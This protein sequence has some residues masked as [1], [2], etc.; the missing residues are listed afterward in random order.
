AP[1]DPTELEFTLTV[2][3]RTDSATDVITITIAKPITRNIKEMSDTLISAQIT[4]SNEITMTYNEELSTFINSYLNFTISNE[5]MPRSITG[6]D[7]SPSRETVA[8]IN[9]QDT[10]VFVT[11]LTFDGQPAPSGS[12]G[13]MYIQHADHYL[14]FIHV[15]DGQD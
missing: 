12:T 9:G 10:N 3:D 11:T 6:I 15:S 13:S 8:R 2:F 7:G 5:D 1:A 4:A 14:A